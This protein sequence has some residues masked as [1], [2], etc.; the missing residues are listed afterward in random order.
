VLNLKRN[1]EYFSRDEIA[2]IIG[3]AAMSDESTGEK[4]PCA[5]V[6]G[7]FDP[8]ANKLFLVSDPDEAV[9]RACN[10]LI[11]TGRCSRKDVTE[12]I[13]PLQLSHSPYAQLRTAFSLVTAV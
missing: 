2:I 6:N 7:K 12:I 9:R 10:S 11:K 8:Y 5:T 3:F 1:G 4:I 13:T